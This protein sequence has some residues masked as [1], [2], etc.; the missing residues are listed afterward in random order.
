VQTVQS[1]IIGIGFQ[2]TGTSSLKAALEML[3]YKVGENHYKLL[4]YI[5]K[6]NYKPVLSVLSRFDAVEDNPW[7]LIYP[8][9]DEK[10]PGCKFILTVRNE[11]DW[12]KSV[13]AHIGTL[14]DPM[15]E[16]I[17]GSGKGLPV[18]NSEN[19]LAVYR[20]HNLD[21][22]AYFKDRPSDLLV[23]NLEDDAKW[24]KLCSFLNKPIPALPYPH[25]NVTLTRTGNYLPRLFKLQ[26]KQLKYSLQIA[27][28]RR[29]GW[30]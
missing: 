20:K 27:W 11:L 22:L 15:H 19:T 26:K 8:K 12:L 14:R 10:V 1:K 6:G 21:A 25:K 29:K 7:P 5:L 4:P 9:I 28:Y 2:K 18:Q 30:L 3:N 16:W 24:E 23:L 17:Y 13:T